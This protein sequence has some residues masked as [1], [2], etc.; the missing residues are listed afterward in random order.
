[1][2][3]DDLTDLG[4]G[5]LGER[6]DFLKNQL[7]GLNKAARAR[8]G[9]G[10]NKDDEQAREFSQKQVSVESEIMDRLWGIHQERSMLAQETDE[11][12]KAPIAESPDQWANSPDQFDWPG[13]DTP[14]K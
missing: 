8:G 4:L 14:K 7:E 2:A 1:M 6:N 13:I 5:D 12:R 11:E 3:Q 10:A 9:T